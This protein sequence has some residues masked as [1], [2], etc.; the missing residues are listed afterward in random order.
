[1]K[2]L[3]P[4]AFLCA[5]VVLLGTLGVYAQQPAPVA[6]KRPLTHKDYDSWRS[7]QAP[8]ISRDG[9]FVAYAYIPQDGDG[10]IVVRNITSGTEWRAPR[11]YAK[12]AIYFDGKDWYSY[13]VATGAVT[14]LTKTLNTNFFN[15]LTDVPSTPEF[16]DH[17]L[18]GAPAPEW[19][20]KGIPFLQRE[21]EKEKY[22]V[23]KEDVQP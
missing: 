10:E 8:Q 14:N 16:F 18:K 3:R 7:I 17:Y 15:E 4:V 19:M 1:M 2:A 5:V 6:A 22:R 12:Y 9:K 13:S 21:K 23:S 11:G 20:G